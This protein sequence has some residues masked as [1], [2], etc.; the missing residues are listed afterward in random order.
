MKALLLLILSVV[1]GG[2]VTVNHPGLPFPTKE[3]MDKHAETLRKNREYKEETQRM[4]EE[5]NKDYNS[6]MPFPTSN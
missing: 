4:I 2:C 6:T 5:R 3:Q 1:C